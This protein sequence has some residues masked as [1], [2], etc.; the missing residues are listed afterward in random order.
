MTAEAGQAYQGLDR[1]EAREAVVQRPAAARVAR[2]NRRL[3]AQRGHMPALQDRHRTAA[4]HAVVHEN[5]AAGRARHSRGGR[6]TDPRSF[7][8]TTRRFISTGWTRFTTGAFRGNSGGGTAFPRGIATPA[9]KSSWRAQT[10]AACPKCANS[11]FARRDG[12]ARHLVQLRPL[13][14]RHPGL[15]GQ[16]RLTCAAFIPTT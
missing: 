14:L 6:R 7:P 12:H 1:Y 3:S 4:L 5:A 13:A 15:A 9:A 10:P 11:L 16:T 8:T 2:E